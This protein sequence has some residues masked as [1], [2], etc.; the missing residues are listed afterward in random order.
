MIQTAIRIAGRI[1]LASSVFVL[2]T[3]SFAGEMPAGWIDRVF[4]R[5]KAV[6]VAKEMTGFTATLQLREAFLAQLIEGNNKEIRSRSRVGGQIPNLDWPESHVA[7]YWQLKDTLNLLNSYEEYRTVVT[8]EYTAKLAAAR[9]IRHDLLATGS[10]LDI[11]RMRGNDWTSFQALIAGNGGEEKSSFDPILGLMTSDEYA[12]NYPQ[13]LADSFW[14]YRGETALSGGYYD[15]AITAYHKVVTQEG[16]PFR[17]FVFVR[18]AF[19]YEEVGD[20]E[21]IEANWKMWVAAGKPNASEGRIQFFTG[22]NRYENSDY[23]GATEALLTVPANSIYKQQSDLILGMCYGMTNQYDNALKTLKPLA[24]DKS[25]GK[26]R[27][28]PEMKLFAKIKYAQILNLAGHSDEALKEISQLSSREMYGDQVLITRAW[29]YRTIPKYG[30]TLTATLDTLITRSAWSPY[31]PMASAWKAELTELQKGTAAAMPAYEKLFTMVEQNKQI[32]DYADER[33]RLYDLDNQ[34]SLVEGD[35]LRANDIGLF[36]K[37]LDERRKVRLLIQRNKYGA[38]L[39]AIPQLQ[40]L[41]TEEVTVGNMVSNLESVRRDVDSDRSGKLM[42]KYIKLQM[43]GDELTSNLDELMTRAN[44]MTPALQRQQDV[45]AF[46]KHIGELAT[47]SKSLF[48]SAKLDE[49]NSIPDRAVLSQL[50]L[51][52]FSTTAL[53]AKLE[54]FDTDLDRA[55][56]FAM[57]RY[58]L[59]GFDFDALKREQSHSSQLDFYIKKLENALAQKEQAEQ[60]KQEADATPDTTKP[61]T[62]PPANA[63]AP[64]TPPEK[65]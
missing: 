56:G 52:R 58:A 10:P 14:F 5:A 11:E 8:Q 9:R 37:F 41:Y 6:H 51:E 34:L 42:K 24:Y 25:V 13:A 31:V 43:K 39:V 26:E 28:T 65:K 38:T 53:T 40:G 35:V 50:K 44:Q 64:T 12:R 48:D 32:A 46:N 60:E 55:S 1:C 54:E 30:D 2:F 3:A 19:L 49:T 18:L 47:K 57:A 23:A 20:A 15:D 59:G 21:N 33:Y 45:L 22:K 61:D 63:P 16:S 7:D 17:R 36:A 62:Q 29:I 4:T 27:V